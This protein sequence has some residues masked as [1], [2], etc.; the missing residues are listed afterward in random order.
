MYESILS[1][2]QNE[3]YLPFV[4]IPHLIGCIDFVGIKDSECLVIE[5]KVNKWKNALKQALKYGYGAEETYIALPN[6]TAG[7]V[8]SKHRKTFEKYGVGIIEVA[9]ITSIVLACE[10]KMPSP[11][12]KQMILNEIQRRKRRRDDRV[13]AFRGR[14]GK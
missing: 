4:Q 10:R 12:F 14:H 1:F 9:E 6:P 7:N 5:G 3:G 2:I 8:A 13:V 11:I